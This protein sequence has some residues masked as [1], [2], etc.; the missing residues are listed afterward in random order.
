M[1]HKGGHHVLIS[2][3]ELGDG[4]MKLFELPVDVQLYYYNIEEKIV[5]SYFPIA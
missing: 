2:T 5:S 1:R 4:S 3:R